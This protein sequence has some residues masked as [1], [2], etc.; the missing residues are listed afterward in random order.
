MM[1]RAARAKA[2]VAFKTA[3]GE[4]TNAILPHG[5][6][7]VRRVE[8]LARLLREQPPGWFA[9]GWPHEIADAL[10]AAVQCLRQ[11]RGERPEEWAWGRVRP[12][13]L[14]HPTGTKAPLDR[15]F[16]RGPI[17]FGGD[18][19]TLPQASVDFLDPLG[20]AIGVPNL[21]MVVDVGN[22]EA[23]R[24]VLAGGQSGNP[25]SPHYDDLLGPWERGEGIPIAWTP[26]SVA[27]VATA[28]LRLVPPKPRGA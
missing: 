19:T 4:G 9:R 16:N 8:H 6:M 1:Q 2:P 12:L 10:G 5:A 15:I 28:T 3:L 24:Y 14:I 11:A 17:A 23:S 7:A 25:M 13:M 20:N 21:R 18:A 26:E 27:R 22:W